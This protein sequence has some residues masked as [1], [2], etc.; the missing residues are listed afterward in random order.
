[1]KINGILK[2]CFSKYFFICLISSLI[3]S[4]FIYSRTPLFIYDNIINTIANFLK[5]VYHTGGHI[6]KID[7]G[8]HQL[9][10]LI[11]VFGFLIFIT[12]KIWKWL[13]V[14]T[15]PTQASVAPSSYYILQKKDWLI[16]TG[17]I[18]T[19]IL[20]R[21]FSLSQSLWQDE[22]AVYN[23]FIKDGIFTTIFPCT[24]MGSHPFMQIIVRCFITI[25]GASD[26]TLRLPIFIISI[27][28]IP[29]IYFDS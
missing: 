22:I 25:F 14:I 27:V 24:S 26:I 10:K 6:T 9:S 16:I 11:L 2:L 23:V 8:I 28:S 7:E 13:L 15:E 21:I 5:A 12:L 1:M 20:L 4:L 29:L 3:V 18:I 19:G 17:F